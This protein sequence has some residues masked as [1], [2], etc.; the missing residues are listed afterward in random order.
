MDVEKRINA[1]VHFHNLTLGYDRHPAVHHL[2]GHVAKGDLLAIAGPNGAGK[3]TL[4]KSIVGLIPPISGE[5]FCST[6]RQSIA[7]LPQSAEIDLGFPIS[8]AEF[9]GMGFWSEQGFWGKLGIFSFL[10]SHLTPKITAA[11]ARVGLSGFENRPIGTLSGGQI[12]RML[13]ARVFIQH[14]PLILLDE[15]FSAIDTHT[16]SELMQLVQQWHKE[17]RTVIAVLHDLRLIAEHFPKT[18]LLARDPLAWGD[19]QN[20]LTEANLS[21]A[22]AM[23][24][25]FDPHAAVCEM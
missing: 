24:A 10:R 1:A 11:L 14:S 25:A 3:S 18:L 15:P 16:V 7:Y 4:L 12:Q 17:G 19:T 9:V 6:P 5:V 23:R 2:S 8:V 20:V 21:R 22:R 13:F